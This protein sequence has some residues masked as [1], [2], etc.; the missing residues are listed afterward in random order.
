VCVF[1]YNLDHSDS[2]FFH[3]NGEPINIDFDFVFGQSPCTRQQCF[4]CLCTAVV[5]TLLA[6][7]SLGQKTRKGSE[8]LSLGES[9]GL[10]S[11]P[12]PGNCQV[13]TAE[14]L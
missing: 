2:D 12:R 4:A 10:L 1:V 7:A 5:V 8:R 3:D 6:V 11:Y 14:P 13:P 9:T